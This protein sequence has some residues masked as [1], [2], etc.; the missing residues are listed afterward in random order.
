MP[1][2]EFEKIT[3]ERQAQGTGDVT[4]READRATP[5]AGMTIPA[6]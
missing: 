2:W 1:V 5:M 4:I 3:A 6:R